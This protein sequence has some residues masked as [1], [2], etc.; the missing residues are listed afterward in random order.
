MMRKTS[1]LALAILAGMLMFVSACGSKPSG[2]GTGKTAKKVNFP[3]KAVDLVVPFKP[4]GNVD[5]CSRIIAPVMEKSLGQPVEVLNK[6]GGGA[7]IGQTYALNAKPDGHTVLVLTSSFATNVLSGNTTYK[8]DSVKMIGQ[9]CYDPEV[10]VVSSALGVKDY[11]SFLDVAKSKELLNTTPGFSTSHHICSL[12]YG[13]K[14]GIK[15]QYMHTNGSAEQTV[16]LA[17]GHADVGFTTYAGAASLIQQ[18]KIIPIAVANDSRLSTLPNVPT[19]KEL[20]LDFKYGSY[21]GLAVSSKVPDDVVEILRDALK[22]AMNDENVKKQFAN[23][24]L[25]VSYTDGP[26][27]EKM[28]REDYKGLES[29]KPMLKK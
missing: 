4:G 8:I 21:R 3:T 17:G 13:Q 15:F 2:G 25:P 19:L 1:K 20:G 14:T 7:V 11:K 26:A 28:V 22:K 10:L 9:M 23:S 16:E 27:F 18:G 5:M 6:P 29:V 12:L 24:G